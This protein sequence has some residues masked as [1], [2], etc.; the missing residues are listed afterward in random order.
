MF[1]PAFPPAA[2]CCPPTPPP[3]TH[4][5]TH[6]HSPRA[7][8]CMLGCLAGHLFETRLCGLL[9]VGDGIAFVKSTLNCVLTQYDVPVNGSNR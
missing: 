6:T 4:T 1:D 2:S 5:H 3:H 9:L 7:C 8:A